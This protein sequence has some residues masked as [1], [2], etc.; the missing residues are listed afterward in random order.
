M[1]KEY[2]MVIGLEVHVELKTKTKIF[3]GSWSI[4][5]IVGKRCIPIIINAGSRMKDIMDMIVKMN[6]LWMKGNVK[7]IV[8]QKL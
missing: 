4:V 1:A 3:F 6:M 5:E 7:E 8:Y 2:E